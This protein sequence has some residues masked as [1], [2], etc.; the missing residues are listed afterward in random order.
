MCVRTSFS[1][2]SVSLW[3]RASSPLHSSSPR[4][5]TLCLLGVLFPLIE[6]RQ[7][8]RLQ[9]TPRIRVLDQRQMAE[10]ILIGH[11]YGVS[12]LRTYLLHCATYIR[13]AHILQT[14]YANVQR[15][16]CAC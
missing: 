10:D 7:I 14:R 2:L 4:V 6:T 3:V 16:E 5:C 9:H 8:D 12:A 11:L 13:R 1:W 15:N